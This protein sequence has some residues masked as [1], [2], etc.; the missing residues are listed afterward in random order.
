[1]S[2][3]AATLP[4]LE[5]SLKPDAA[6]AHERLR[7]YWQG[8]LVDRA[9]VNIRAPKAGTQGGKRSLIVAEDFDFPAA[10]DRFEQWAEG[11]F[12]GGEALPVLMPNYGPDQW[13]G[14]LGAALSLVPEMDTSWVEPLL[15]DREEI[16]PLAIDPANRWWRAIVDLTR[17]AGRRCPGKFLVSTIDTHSNL[18]CLSAL[19]GPE[20]LC[21]DLLERPE[22]IL[23][24]LGEIDALYEPIYTAIYD[25]G[26]MKEFGSTSWLE[27]WSEGR[28]QA[29][30]CDFCCMI[31]RDHFRR[32][33]LP[34]LEREMACLDHA[35][36]H[37]DGPGQ[38]RHLDDLLAMPRLHTIQW[39]PGAGEAAA[40][41]WVEMLQKIQK[42]GKGVQVLVT[43][44]ELKAL[45]G[46]LAPEKTFYWVMDCPGESEARALLQWMKA[47]T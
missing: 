31:S 5:L 17:L 42:A 40:P 24:A 18:D 28:T 7:A 15:R 19:R 39:V 6:E 21:M 47:H 3:F 45:Y 36:Y 13:A 14:F 43:A 29:V 46:H 30:Q 11:M 34:S 35:V 23:R 33:A 26:R 16:P 32:F 27:M 41:A 25:A 8:Q 37:M 12:Y 2:R 38:I 20:R 10:I 9:C 44:E 1:M 22:A 4:P